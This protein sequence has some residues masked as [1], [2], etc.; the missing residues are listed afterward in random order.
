[1]DRPDLKSLILIGVL[2]LVVA[3]FGYN[4]LGAFNYPGVAGW[5]AEAAKLEA[6]RNKLKANIE[7]AQLMVA[8]LDKV[9]KDRE[10]LEAQLKELVKR[11]P[12]ER[13]SAEVLR[14][15]ESLAGRSG[16]TLGGVK[17]RPVRTQ[18]LYAELPMEV[19]LG[20]GYPDVVKFA[21]QLSRLDRLVTL[22]EFNVQ[23]PAPQPGR[24]ASADAA[25]MVKAQ[26]V[27]VVFQALPESPSAGGPGAPAAEPK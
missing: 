16:L 20:G 22:N 25:G 10:M 3:Y 2:I 12:G 19:G 5:Q 8:N 15:V 24:Q 4:G 17:R 7:S 18:E 11:L 9:K 26:L 6:E 14:S 1:M 27:T 13:E 21:D 23:R